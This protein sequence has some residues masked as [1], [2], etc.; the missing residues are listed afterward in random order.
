MQMRIS[1]HGWLGFAAMTS[2]S[3]REALE[4]AVRFAPTRTPAIALRVAE[5]GAAASLVLE[6][7]VAL[8]GARETILVAL[9]VGIWQIGNAITGRELAGDADLAF[10]APRWFERFRD[11]FPGA[12]R[13]DRP[14]NQL[15]FPA[16]T[17]DVPLVLADPA[18]LRLAR[19]QCERELGALRTGDDFAGRVR[20]ALVGAGGPFPT[21]EQVAR[22]L[23]VSPRTLK[24]RLAERGTSFSELLDELRRDRALLLLRSSDVSLDAVAERLGYSDVANFTRAF[25][26]WTGTT[27]GAFRR[28]GGDSR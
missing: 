23:H 25:R 8:G 15:V 4:L 20:G 21:L 3:V 27:P 22:T 28:G 19:E 16:A 18:A 11:R 24:R 13:F 2:S 6:E 26:R 10:P 1:A 14:T 5:D 12:V 17:L 7:R 9:L